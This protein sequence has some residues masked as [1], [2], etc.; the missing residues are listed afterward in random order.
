MASGTTTLEAMLLKKPMV[1]AYRFAALSYFL[2]SVWL[3]C[4]IFSA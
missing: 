4:L 3:K 1:V 2:I